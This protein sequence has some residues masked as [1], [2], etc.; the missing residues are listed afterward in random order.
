MPI[1]V[2]IMMMTHT[3]TKKQ[4]LFPDNEDVFYEDENWVRLD[5]AAIMMCIMVLICIHIFV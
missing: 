1:W 5:G 3:N 4:S 2:I